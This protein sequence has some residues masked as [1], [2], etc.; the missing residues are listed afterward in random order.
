[1]K[2]LRVFI[3]VLFGAL[4][5]GATVACGGDDD[6]A[7]TGQPTATSPAPTREPATDTPEPTEAATEPPAP[8]G[9][10]GGG[11]DDEVQVQAADFSFDPAGFSVP[12]AVP[13]KIEV[14]NAGAFPHT[15]TVYS[16]QAYSSEVE[17]ADTG[18]IAAGENASIETTFQRGEF[19]FRCDIHPTQMEGTL[20]AE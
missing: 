1:V 13:V 18:N 14:R 17:G 16:D 19:F 7:D 2:R 10:A 4:L 12:A 9:A 6:E 5:V 11:L 3:P 20:T 8:T 15:L